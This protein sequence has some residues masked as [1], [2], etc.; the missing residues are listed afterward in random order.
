MLRKISSTNNMNVVDQSCLCVFFRD[1]VD[2]F[3]QVTS[4]GQ[5]R[6]FLENFS[7]TDDALRDLEAV[8]INGTHTVTCGLTV[9]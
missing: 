5:A 3:S 8:N 4:I 7:W 9:K 2:E 1:M 6:D